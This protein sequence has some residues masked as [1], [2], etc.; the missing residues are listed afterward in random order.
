MISTLQ[1]TWAGASDVPVPTVKLDSVKASRHGHGGRNLELVRDSGEV[2]AC[3]LARKV[4]PS[5][6]EH[7]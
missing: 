6:I 5:R 4:K 2:S 3:H 1:T 7:K